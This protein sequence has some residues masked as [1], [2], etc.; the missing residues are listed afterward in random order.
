MIKPEKY[1]ISQILVTALKSFKRIKNLGVITIESEK[2][3]IALGKNW[4]PK[5]KWSK[6]LEPWMQLSLESKLTAQAA[7]LLYLQGE[8]SRII[9]STGQTAGPDWP[10]E[11]TAMA[12]YA[13]YIMSVPAKAI[14]VEEVSLDTPGNAE[15]VRNM[16]NQAEFLISI[17]SHL[18]RS[19]SYFKQC[20]IKVKR[21]VAS[22]QVV[23]TRSKYHY[24]LVH[25]YLF[26]SRRIKELGTEFALRALRLIDPS[27]SLPRKLAKKIRK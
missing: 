26:S 14:V 13:Q 4:R 12:E 25:R 17:G 9:F 27:G 18:K 3:G 7:S 2:I 11:A 5:K 10:S 1:G 8:I 23:A 20:G 21:L 16:T 24:R 19:D 15:E 6:K 22:E